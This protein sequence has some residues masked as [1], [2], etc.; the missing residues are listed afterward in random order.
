MFLYYNN[1]KSFLSKAIILAISYTTA[2]R[3]TVM[4]S[5]PPLD[6]SEHPE[7]DKVTKGMGVEDRIERNQDRGDL[8][9][10]D[11][12]WVSVAQ[13]KK[14]LTKYEVK[15]SNEDG[16]HRVEIPDEILASPTPLWKTL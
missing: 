9:K 11:L 2:K 6:L 10:V 4:D 16:K 13:D 1:T 7:G 3:V 15:V 14:R 12:S 5:A 8:K